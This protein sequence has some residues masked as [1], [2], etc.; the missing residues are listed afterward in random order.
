MAGAPRDIK[1]KMRVLEYV[2]ECGN[3]ARACRHFG[4][5]RQYRHA[6]RQPM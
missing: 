5:S 2:R 3:I 4:I 1:R 6:S